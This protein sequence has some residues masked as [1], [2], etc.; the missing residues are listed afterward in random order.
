MATLWTFPGA[1][2]GS[3]LGNPVV[4]PDPAFDPASSRGRGS[5]SIRDALAGKAR[6]PDTAMDVTADNARPLV[7]T[8]TDGA[9]PAL[10]P[11][12]VV[13]RR[14]RQPRTGWNWRRWVEFNN[15]ADVGAHGELVAGAAENPGHQQPQTSQ[16]RNTYRQAPAPWDTAFYVSPA[17]DEG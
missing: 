14:A 6:N 17:G 2:H 8:V 9:P 7:L 4:S 1:P 11:A 5:R 3:P 13:T 12:G 10:R 15:H 16:H